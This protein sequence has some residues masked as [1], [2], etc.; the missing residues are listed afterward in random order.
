ML[1]ESVGDVEEKQK[2][3]DPLSLPLLVFPIDERLGEGLVS[4]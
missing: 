4:A 3:L 2:Q 1:A